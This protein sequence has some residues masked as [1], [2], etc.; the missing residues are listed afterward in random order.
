MKHTKQKA[1]TLL[2]LLLAL[3]LVVSAC[4][5]SSNSGGSKDSNTQTAAN[6]DTGSKDNAAATNAETTSADGAI[7]P[8]KLKPYK[9]KVVY[10]G[11]PQ[12]DEA[13]VEEALNK[14]LTEKINATIDLRPIDWGAWDD[15]MNLLIA[16]REPVDVLFTAQWNGYS[17]NVAK[18]AF[19][20]LGPLLD[21]YGQGIKNLLTQPSWKA[22]KLMGK[23]MECRRTRSWPPQLV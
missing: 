8:S 9:L 4:G 6:T 16:S 22:R 19:L 14:L 10:E 21:K 1:S 12:A 20:D 2:M 5:K 15:K 11:P 18:G 17:K 7:D 23:T 3:A 13:K